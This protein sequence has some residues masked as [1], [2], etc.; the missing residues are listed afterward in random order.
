LRRKDKKSLGGTSTEALTVRERSPNQQ[1]G[2]RG[3][4]KLGHDM[5]TVV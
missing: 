5:V 4:K 3:R 1:G 2:D